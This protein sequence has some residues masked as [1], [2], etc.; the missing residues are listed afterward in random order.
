MGRPGYLSIYADEKMKIIFDRF[1]K[2]KGKSKSQILTEMLEIYMLS[3]DEKLYLELRKESLNIDKAKN[4]IVERIDRTLCNDFIFSKLTYAYGEKGERLEGRE[5]VEAYIKNLV[6]NNLGYTWFST[7]SMHSGMS[8]KKVKYYNEMIRQGKKVEFLIALAYPINDI[9]YIATV[10]E[11]RSSK[12][13]IS[14]PEEVESVPEEFRNEGQAKI[15][16]KLTN[17]QKEEE[18]KASM[19]KIRSTGF[20]LKT[21]IINSQYQYG[22]VYLD[23]DKDNSSEGQ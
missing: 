22:Y 15:W 2:R 9:S 11:I 10:S 17:I 3:D 21:A 1:A 16:L 23:N 18:I 13:G 7:N 14:R 20:N 8:R 4:L 5:V 12:E 19:L 6:E